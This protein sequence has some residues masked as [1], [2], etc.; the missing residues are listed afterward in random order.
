MIASPQLTNEDLFL[1]RRFFREDLGLSKIDYRVPEQSLSAG[2]NFL[3]LAD[4]NPN[5]R[6]ADA[7]LMGGGGFNL[8]QLLQSPPTQ[9]FKL[10]YLFEQDLVKKLGEEDAKSFLSR[11]EYVIYQGANENETSRLADLVLPS[12]TY[13]EVEGTFT[14]FEGTSP[15][16]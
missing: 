12:A 15:E 13:A 14:N 6:G 4:R 8:H 10:L 2:D 3:L 7:I 1:I 16:N 9:S 5:T 11:F